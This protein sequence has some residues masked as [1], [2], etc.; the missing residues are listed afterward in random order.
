MI[1]Q[2]KQQQEAER[3]AREAKKKAEEE[4]IK[5][6]REKKL[7]LERQKREQE[8]LQKEEE[9]K[10]REEERLK[11]EEEKKRRIKEEKERAAEKEKKR[12]EKEEKERLEKE[13]IEK[14]LKEQNERLKR[15]A[16]A[17]IPSPSIPTKTTTSPPPGI[18]A[19]VIENFD[20]SENRQ[21]ALIDALVGPRPLISATN[22]PSIPIRPPP[23]LQ[24][25][26]TSFMPSHLDIL[27]NGPP[28]SLL[29]NTSSSL[30][31]TTNSSSIMGIFNN[32]VGS[33]LESN[34]STRQGRS[35]TPIA[36][37]GQPLNGRRVSSVVPTTH[38]D[39]QTPLSDQ[40]PSSLKRSSVASPFDSEAGPRSFFS[41]FLFGEPT[42]RNSN[43]AVPMMP[44]PSEY[45]MR[46]APPLQQPPQQHQQH[47]D[48][49]FSSDI[50]GHNNWSNGWTAS[51]V[52]SDNVHGKLFGDA[53]VKYL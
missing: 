27:Q 23:L 33:P 42:A 30:S 32:R 12:K 50:S 13:K 17:K 34:N 6:E 15:E 19:P 24:Q 47:L 3:L 31:D 46:F 37:I 7:A 29:S 14:E 9:K 28:S 44:P 45:D 21:Q 39:M 49:R 41:S 52:L 40:F 5:R 20:D 25:Q 43:P 18:P 4:A 22:N 26:Q 36:P 35:I 38:H 53:L 51:S 2:M 11:K 1:R 10:H 48:R 16:K 8:R